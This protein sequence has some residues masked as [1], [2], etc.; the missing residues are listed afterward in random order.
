RRYASPMTAVGVHD[1]DLVVDAL[2]TRE[3]D[4]ASVWRPT[5]R[6][7]ARRLTEVPQAPAV[8]THHVDVALPVEG[9]QAV[10]ARANE[11]HRL[12]SRDRASGAQP[13]AARAQTSRHMSSEEMVTSCAEEVNLRVQR[14]QLRRVPVRRRLP[15]LG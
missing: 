11:S 9:D 5:R 3:S 7:L 12:H 13:T 4:L 1:K 2:P 8:R 14:M 10:L 15:P 6:H